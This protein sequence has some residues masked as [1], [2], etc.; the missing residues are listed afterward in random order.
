MLYYTV[1][2]NTAGVTSVEVQVGGHKLKLKD[3]TG[4]A[5]LNFLPKLGSFQ[6]DGQLVTSSGPAN[7]SDLLLQLPLPV[8]GVAPSNQKPD[9]TPVAHQ[10]IDANATFR[11]ALNAVDP[12]GDS[13]QYTSD[14][15][16][17][18]AS[19]SPQTG[20]F[21]WT[22]TND[23]AGT[24]TIQFDATDSR[25]GQSSIR[26]RFGVT[27]DSSQSPVVGDWKFNS[28]PTDNLDHSAYGFQA[29]G[30]GNPLAASNSVEFQGRGSDQRVE[31]QATAAHRPT[32]AITLRAVVQPTTRKNSFA[33][34]IRYESGSIEA[35]SLTVKDG[36]SMSD[37]RG[38]QQGYW[39]AVRTE[40]GTQRV[41]ARITDWK[42][43]GFDEVV[44]VFDGSRDGG[45][46]DLYVNGNLADSQ[47][48]I[49]V[50][51]VYPGYGGQRVTIGGSG[52]L[53]RTFGGRIAEAQ[54][55]TIPQSPFDLAL[56][57]MKRTDDALLGYL[58]T[59]H[60][61]GLEVSLS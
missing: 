5:K 25:N 54:I 38:S 33:P 15:L 61:G 37:E 52:D 41:S 27:F 21:I 32:D 4:T 10:T 57:P 13:I 56:V 12:D 9:F 16:P 53:G 47:T 30:V 60:I 55:A 42:K 23:Q 51:L 7:S 58:Q 3:L 49:G 40:K 17:A 1:L 20:E 34:L 18:G 50:T 8:F 46:L 14:N 44:G 19:I 43:R 29:T 6:I 11:L 22:P 48:N 45:R 59:Q 26:V 36:G 39:F 24:R 35:Y 31:I 2:G 28:R